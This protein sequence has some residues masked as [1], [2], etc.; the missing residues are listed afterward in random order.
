MTATLN[1][2]IRNWFKESKFEYYEKTSW[3]YDNDK[4]WATDVYCMTLGFRC[5]IV[6]KINGEVIL[7]T[8][9]KWFCDISLVQNGNRN[10][11]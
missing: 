4:A 9:E 6:S 11:V 2:I 10:Y 7:L 5:L 8:T 3:T 1:A